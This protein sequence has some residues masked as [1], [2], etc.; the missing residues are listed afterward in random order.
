[1][2]GRVVSAHE[3]SLPVDDSAFREGRGCFST[4][5]WTGAGL[6]FEARHLARLA[7]DAT[8]LGIGR[9]DADEARRA[10]HELGLVAFGDAEGVLRLQASRG[11]EGRVRLVATAR[12]LGPDPST[13]RAI[14]LPAIHDGAVL[15]RG[16]KVS[17]R[18]LH[19]LAS[20][21]LAESGMDEGLLFDSQGRLV[22]GT[23]SNLVFLAPGGVACTPPEARGAVAGIALEVAS[24]HLEIVRA[25]LLREDVAGAQELVALNAVRRAVAIVELDG[26][27]VGDGRPG[28]LAARLAA[29]LDVAV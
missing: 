25:D 7:R 19:A 27:P 14:T 10:Y 21:Q 23:R 15:Y 18:L 9:V 2:G 26:R 22:E 17:N 29:A 12:S 13:F 3:P 8:G 6:R 1:M 4:A 11:P 16:A 24:E 5:R 28:P 20:D